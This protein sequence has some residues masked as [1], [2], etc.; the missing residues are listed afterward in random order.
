MLTHPVKRIYFK[1]D[2]AEDALWTVDLP[3]PVVEALKE[4]GSGGAAM[5]NT[6][7]AAEAFVVLKGLC[8]ALE[9]PYCVCREHPERGR[10]V[11]IDDLD[12]AR[13]VLHGAGEISDELVLTPSPALTAGSWHAP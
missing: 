11:G 10:F 6:Q 13:R 7:R 9:G 12:Q 8:A 5:T 4:V 3:L 2:R 1:V